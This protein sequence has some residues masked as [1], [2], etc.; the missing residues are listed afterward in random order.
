MPEHRGNKLIQ[1]VVVLAIVSP[2]T[3]YAA[4]TAWTNLV[5]IQQDGTPLNDDG[6]RRCS[7]CGGEAHL[8]G[9]NSIW[10][11]KC[12]RTTPAKQ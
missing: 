4:T 11:F 3:I 10:C 1:F 7:Y 12:D 8:M 5:Y 9:D 6:N 2:L